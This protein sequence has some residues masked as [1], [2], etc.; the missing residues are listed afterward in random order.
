MQKNRKYYS[1]VDFHYFREIDSFG[2]YNDTVKNSSITTK[3]LYLILTFRSHQ[4]SRDLHQKKLVLSSSESWCDDQLSHQES[5]RRRDSNGFS[6]LFIFDYSLYC[7]VLWW[8]I[9]NLV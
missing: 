1:S 6:L 2:W 7:I 4:S 5:G 9:F 3:H 8:H